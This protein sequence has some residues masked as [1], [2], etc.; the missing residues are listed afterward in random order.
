MSSYELQQHESDDPRVVRISLTGELDLTNAREL[1]ERLQ[2]IAPADALLVLDLNCT[3]FVDSAVLHVLFRLARQRG[4]ERFA[5][6]IDSDSVVRRT[7]DIAGLSEAVRVA[8]TPEDVTV[9]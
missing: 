2:G 7:I 5:L 4:S 6:V 1:D 8:A 3:V 9:R